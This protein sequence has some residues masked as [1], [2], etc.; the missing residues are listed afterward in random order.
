LTRTLLLY[1]GG[2]SRGD[3]LGAVKWSTQ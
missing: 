1:K 3:F 2:L